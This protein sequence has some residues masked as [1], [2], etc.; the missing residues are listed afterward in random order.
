MQGD[1]SELYPRIR[2]TVGGCATTATKQGGPT[3]KELELTR[4]LWKETGKTLF[5]LQQTEE[6]L[7]FYLWLILH[8]KD[9]RAAALS[10][11]EEN[12][13][14]P[15]GA[16]LAKLR[17]SVK[18]PD[19]LDDRLKAFKDERNWLAHR[20]GREN[21]D[22][23]YN[24]EKFRTLLKRL[25]DLKREGKAISDMFATLCEQ[26]LI[27]TGD[28]T[29]DQLDAET[30]RLYSLRVHRAGKPRTTRDS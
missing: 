27:A 30:L 8:P 13:E 23:V 3:E 16:L 5:F 20:I 19:N 11:L 21:H 1:E 22:D 7:G 28:T 17:K 26:W 29:K 15:L 9:D 14:K 10:M 6:V 2:A 25:D 12:W 18:V 4:H 24:R